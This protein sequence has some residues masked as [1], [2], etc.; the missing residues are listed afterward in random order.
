MN[1][2][3]RGKR[4]ILVKKDESGYKASRKTSSFIRAIHP[5]IMYNA[6]SI[7]FTLRSTSCEKPQCCPLC[8][9]VNST[10]NSLIEPT[11]RAAAANSPTTQQLSRLVS[12]A[13]CSNH[14]PAVSYTRNSASVNASRATSS[15]SKLTFIVDN[16]Q[17][18]SVFYNQC[19]SKYQV[20]HD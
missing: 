14:A 10:I 3:N 18:V 13:S 1:K 7:Q 2:R 20:R 5:T 15:N 6:S 16:E 12:A 8:Q 4:V 17:E 19:R 9:H 11:L